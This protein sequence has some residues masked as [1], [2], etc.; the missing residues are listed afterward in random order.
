VIEREGAGFRQRAYVKSG[1]PGIDDRFGASVALSG[2]GALLTA[3]AIGE[4]SAAT[5]V[6]GDRSSD[7]APGAGAV[8]TFTR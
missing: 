1:N 4:D 8:Y 2:D 3:G 7:A 5:G 6:G